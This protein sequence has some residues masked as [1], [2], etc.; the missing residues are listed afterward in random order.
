MLSSRGDKCGELCS[1]PFPPPLEQQP[2]LA[3]EPG[4]Q[5]S[6]SFHPST[7]QQAPGPRGYE[8]VSGAWPRSGPPGR[9]PLP[10]CRFR[11]PE[12]PLRPLARRCGSARGPRWRPRG[13]RSSR[14]RRRGQARG[15]SGAGARGRARPRRSMSVD[16]DDEV[17]H[18]DG[19][20]PIQASPLLGPSPGTSAGSSRSGMWISALISCPSALAS[21]VPASVSRQ[22]DSRRRQA[23]A[24][25]QPRAAEG[26]VAA[27]G[28]P[29]AVGSS[30][31]HADGAATGRREH[32]QAVRAD[33]VPPVA[34]RGDASERS[35]ARAGLARPSSMTKSLPDPVILIERGRLSSG[36]PPEILSRSHQTIQIASR[37]I[38]LLILLCPSTRSVKTIGSLHQPESF[39]PGPE[40]HLDLEGIPVGANPLPGR[41]PRAPADEST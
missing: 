29:G 39:P 5:C 9:A 17:R 14:W 26:R 36:A 15:R 22:S 38:R 1:N 7:H 35:T 3:T 8:I 10:P 6:T 33:P 24:N 37:T 18:A 4:V 21:T 40:A 30:E 28:R 31:G 25:R 12:S 23:K 27:H 19:S 34:H 11:R 2:A 41:S 32:H 20:S 16:P 13:P